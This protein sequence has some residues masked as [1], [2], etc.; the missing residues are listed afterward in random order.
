MVVSMS[1]ILREG[2]D[3]GEFS[4]ISDTYTKRA[5]VRKERFEIVKSYIKHKL[6]RINNSFHVLPRA[7]QERIMKLGGK[8]RFETVGEFLGWFRGL[9]MRERERE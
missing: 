7:I 6:Q 1:G 2:R 8:E 3:G 9:P 4:T 5:E